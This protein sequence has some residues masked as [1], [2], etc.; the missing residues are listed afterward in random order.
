[1]EPGGKVDYDRAMTF[2]RTV[3]L[4]AVGAVV[5]VVL[6]VWLTKGLP[7]PVLE[8]GPT[9]DNFALVRFG[10]SVSEVEALLGPADRVTQRLDVRLGHYASFDDDLDIHIVFRDNQGVVQAFLRSESG[11]YELQQPPS[12]LDRVKAWL[13]L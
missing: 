12:V 5:G 4:V 7:E 9:I 6:G 10:M 11:H 13:N 1:M 2:K 8:P 3:L